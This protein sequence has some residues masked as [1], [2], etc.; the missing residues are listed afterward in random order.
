[1]RYSENF[2]QLGQT[3]RLNYKEINGIA[4][5]FQKNEKLGF[6]WIDHSFLSGEYKDK[7]KEL[8]ES[9][10]ANLFS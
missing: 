9:G 8:I 1:M 7:Y 2:E 5:R 3:M 4:K 6:N 10:Y